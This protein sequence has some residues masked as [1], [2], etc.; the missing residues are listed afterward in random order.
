MRLDRQFIDVALEA[1]QGLV[2]SAKAAAQA[3]A[4][5]EA[6]PDH[7]RALVLSVQVLLNWWRSV[8]T[9]F[10]EFKLP[11]GVQ[12]ALEASTHPFGFTEAG[13]LKCMDVIHLLGL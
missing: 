10:P 3:E 12:P 5:G 9:R 7:I 2:L 11:V 8:A 1:I 6:N 13:C 4:D